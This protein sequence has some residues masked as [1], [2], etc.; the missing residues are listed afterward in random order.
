MIS[1]FGAFALMQMLN[2]LVIIGPILIIA[3]LF[4]YA[5]RESRRSTYL[6]L[7]AGTCCT[8]IG[9][10]CLFCELRTE[11]SQRSLKVQRYESLRA[12]PA[13]K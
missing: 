2:S 1:D 6:Y 8:L 10:A 4:F 13:R 11:R 9:G 3:G 5:F 7:I 12:E